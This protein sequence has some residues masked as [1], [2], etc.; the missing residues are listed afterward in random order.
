MGIS[1]EH[2]WGTFAMDAYERL[3]TLRETWLYYC[4]LASMPIDIETAVE[5]STDGHG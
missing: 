5:F 3:G 1:H 2:L 4:E